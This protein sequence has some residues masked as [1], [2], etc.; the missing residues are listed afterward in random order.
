[1][2]KIEVQ[3]SS[4]CVSKVYFLY[5]TVVTTN[6]VTICHLDHKSELSYFQTKTERNWYPDEWYVL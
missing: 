1:M 2:L 6:T 5:F 4:S 3:C